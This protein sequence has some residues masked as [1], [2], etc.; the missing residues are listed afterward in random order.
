MNQY[1]SGHGL[2]TVVQGCIIEFQK[3]HIK[4]NGIVNFIPINLFEKIT[5]MD[6]SC[7]LDELSGLNKIV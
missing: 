5:L 2:K 7:A 4:K 6:E 3:I 1:L